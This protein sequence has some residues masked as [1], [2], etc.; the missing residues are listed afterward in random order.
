M[1]AKIRE[2]ARARVGLIHEMMRPE[3]IKAKMLQWAIPVSKSTDR[4]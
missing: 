3:Q 1:V 2:K 4:R